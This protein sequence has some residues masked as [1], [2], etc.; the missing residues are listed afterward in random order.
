MESGVTLRINNLNRMKNKIS[1]LLALIVLCTGFYFLGNSTNNKSPL[2]LSNTARL[3]EDGKSVKI[4]TGEMKGGLGIE[5]VFTDIQNNIINTLSVE[6]SNIGGPSYKIV[7]GNKHDWLVVTTIIESG[8]GYIKYIDSWYL[9]AN[10]YGG[11][12]KVLS[13]D[14]KTSEIDMFNI[15]NKETT[16]EVMSSSSDDVLDIKFTKKICKE[17]EECSISSKINHYVWNI[18]TKDE[19]KSGFILK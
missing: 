4:F 19:S 9:V 17:R 6:N 12:Q 10:W 18:D 1:Y 3:M 15:Y 16:S 13:Y 5:F 11:I 7:R 2:K 8:T 14:S